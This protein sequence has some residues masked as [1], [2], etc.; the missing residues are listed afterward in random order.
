MRRPEK[1][2]CFPARPA[3][4]P[5]TLRDLEIFIFKD[6][7]EMVMRETPRLA[8]Y[9]NTEKFI[10]KL[11]IRF[12]LS[13]ISLAYCLYFIQARVIFT[14]RKCMYFFIKNYYKIVIKIL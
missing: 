3:A 9:A 6:R 4:D 1:S 10:L 13:P 5:F 14:N 2:P 7:P 12:T 11:G 8:I